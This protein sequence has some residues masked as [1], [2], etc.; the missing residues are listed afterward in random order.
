MSEPEQQT[1]ID[2]PRAIRVKT[3]TGWAEL[4]IQ[5]PPGQGVPIGGTSGQALVKNSGTNYDTSWAAAGSDLN[6][7]GDYASGPTYKDGE[8]V[9]YNGV[10]YM[11]VTPTS[12]PPSAWPGAPPVAQPAPYI[13]GRGTTLPASPTDGQEYVLVDSLTTPTYQWRFR[14]AAG[15]TST[16]KWEFVGGIPANAGPGG[17][18]NGFTWT[19]W[20]SLSSSPTFTTPRAGDYLFTF[21]IFLQSAAAGTFEAYSRLSVGAQSTS[22][23]KAVFVGT[24]NGANVA[25]TERLNAVPASSVVVIQIANQV[26]TIAANAGQGWFSVTPARVA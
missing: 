26:S 24:Y 17:A 5:G 19:G 14:Y 1:T 9:V 4:V 18:T 3:T 20:N 2:A 11:C 7:D 15:S 12:S 22:L 23:I 10:A 21:G 25:G 16:Y 6:Y 8:I 13:V